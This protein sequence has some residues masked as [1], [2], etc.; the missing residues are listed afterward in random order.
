MS[1]I[2]RSPVSEDDAPKVVHDTASL[3]ASR[4][5]HDLISPIG[6]ISNGMELLVMSGLPR[7]P[8]LALIEESIANANARVRL[9]R[10]AFGTASEGQK[11][12][13]QDVVKLLADCYGTGRVSVQWEP[14]SDLTRVQAKL[15]LLAVLCLE[16][17]LPLGGQIVVRCERDQWQMQAYGEKIRYDDD[18][19]ATLNSSLRGALAPAHVQF[20][21]LRE[22]LDRLG[23]EPMCG[24]SDSAVSI[25]YTL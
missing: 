4:I 24:H 16:V 7:S 9:F 21:L 10:L 2:A 11:F 3:L 6:A 17:T 23:A 18:V 12:S 1:D 20:I 8:E 25:R 14:V 13:R 5:C 19:W 22:A 15:A